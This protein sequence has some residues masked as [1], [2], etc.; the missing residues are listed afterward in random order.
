MMKNSAGAAICRSEDVDRSVEE[1]QKW[2]G[3]VIGERANE[4]QKRSNPSRMTSDIE[5]KSSSNESGP[6]RAADKPA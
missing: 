3:R 6:R 5:K 1:E 4:K 2:L